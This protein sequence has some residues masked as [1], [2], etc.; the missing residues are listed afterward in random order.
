[1]TGNGD[2]WM[3]AAGDQHGVAVAHYGHNF[4]IFDVVVD[5][6]NAIGGSG[7]VEIHIYLFQQWSV[8][9]GRPT[10]P[11][12]RVGDGETDKQSSRLNVLTHHHGHKTPS[13]CSPSAYIQT[14][15]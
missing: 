4:R 8:F 11:V 2:V 1:M 5:E 10:G 13:P 15:V 14:N 6:L 9:V 3:E 12:A 7:H